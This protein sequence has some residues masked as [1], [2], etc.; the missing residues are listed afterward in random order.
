VARIYGVDGLIADWRVLRD[1]RIRDR[2]T[3]AF[4]TITGNGGIVPNLRKLPTGRGFLGNFPN[5]VVVSVPTTGWNP[6][7]GTF[8]VVGE[9]PGATSTCYALMWRK[10]TNNFIGLYTSGGT[11]G[12]AYSVVKT[13][14]TFYTGRANRTGPA[15]P[16]VHVG[17]WADGAP[18]QCY[19]NGATTSTTG[20][21][22]V[23]PA[24]LLATA[25]LGS[26]I[27]A[28]GFYTAGLGRFLVFNRALSQAEVAQFTRLLTEAAP[29]W[30]SEIGG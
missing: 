10:D 27:G 29:L 13:A 12:N 6:A 18:V 14:G 26:N 3:G 5:T 17:T 11:V 4:A 16:Y 2:L 19:A 30:A 15:S 28:D 1:G 20:G 7:A 25:S 22:A 23:I 21:N 9:D 8:I 24:G